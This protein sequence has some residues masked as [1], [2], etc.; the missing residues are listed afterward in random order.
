[1]KAFEAIVA[2]FR[3]TRNSNHRSGL[4]PEQNNKAN[5]IVAGIRRLLRRLQRSGKLP[6]PSNQQ[7]PRK[8]RNLRGDLTRD[9]AALTK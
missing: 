1:M 9:E 2:Y 4:K 3:R 8:S 5:P 7:R 6:H